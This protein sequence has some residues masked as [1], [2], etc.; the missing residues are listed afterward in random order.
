MNWKKA[1]QQD[2]PRIMEFLA[3]R[4]YRAATLASRI[5]EYGIPKLPPKKNGSLWYLPEAE[6]NKGIRGLVLF[7]S[8]GLYLPLFH[9]THPPRYDELQDILLR[10]RKEYRA[11]YCLLGREEDVRLSEE[12]LRCSVSERK[13]FYLMTRK[14]AEEEKGEKEKRITIPRLSVRRLS[15]DDAERFF[16]VERAYQIEEVVTDPQ[17]YNEEAGLIHFRNQCRRQLIFGAMVG[18]IPVAKAG[19]NAIAFRYCQIGGVYTRP[20][21]RGMGIA[22]QTLKRVMAAVASR[23]QYETLYVRR[24]NEAAV[25]LYRSLGFRTRCSYAITYPLIQR[26]AGA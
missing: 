22:Y 4:E 7:C 8:N 15:A 10:F 26:S 13:L 1:G 3:P 14:L 16:P 19:T 23:G 18:N 5:Q 24:D 12:A 17:H 2:L 25:A 9:E 21:Y 11:I 6:D 20:E